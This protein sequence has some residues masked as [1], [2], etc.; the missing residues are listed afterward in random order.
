MNISQ[1]VPLNLSSTVY[2]FSKTVQIYYLSSL[3]LMMLRA[4]ICLLS[5]YLD[6]QI[7]M[8]A[9]DVSLSTFL[10]GILYLLVEAPSR[11]L[12]QLLFSRMRS[13]KTLQV[14]RYVGLIGTGRFV[15]QPFIL[16][17]SFIKQLVCSGL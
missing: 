4:C 17:H 10:A 14:I 1:R 13:V 15:N 16:L 9:A 8:V 3:L 2:P 5:C 11:T 6:L 12:V 7:W